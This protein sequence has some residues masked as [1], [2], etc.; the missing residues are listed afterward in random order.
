[1]DSNVHVTVDRCATGLYK[2]KTKKQQAQWE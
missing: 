1:M 2:K